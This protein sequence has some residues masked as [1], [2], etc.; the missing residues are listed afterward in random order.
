MSFRKALVLF[1][2][3]CAAL[4][5]ADARAENP[6]WPPPDTVTDL[7]DPKWWPSDSSYSGMWELFS[8]IPDS[9]KATVRQPELALG[10]GVHADRAWQK[11]IGD[12]R[13]LIAVLD[14]G[15]RWSE[16]DLVNKMYLNR[17]ELPEPDAA[18][19]TAAFDPLK[20]YDA[21]GDGVF[22]VQDYTSNS[23]IQEPTLPCDPRVLNYAG[24][25]DTNGNGVLDGQDLI[26]IFA[27][28]VDDD[29]NGYVDDIS[30]WD[31]FNNDNDPND[32]T[33]FGHG[34]G[35]ARDSSAEGN[36]NRGDIGVCPKCT[37]MAVRVGD[38]FVVDANNFALGVLFATDSGAAVVQE[39]TGAINNNQL[40]IGAIDYAY[41]NGVVIIGSAA[42]ENAFHANFPGAN[43]HT[44]Y[45]HAIV[46]DGTKVSTSTTF[47]N[48]NNCTNYGPRLELSTPGTGC[49]SEATGKTSGIAGLVYAAALKADIPFPTGQA[50][51]TDKFGAR[52]LTAEEVR[53]LLIN[54]VDDINVPESKT[55]PSKYPSRAGWE[56]RFGYGR[57]NARSAVDAVL[58]GKIPPEVDLASPGWFRVFYPERNSDQTI[59]LA[60]R[61]TFRKDR[62]QSMDVV[63]EW[64]PG[65]NP[66]ENQFQVLD[67]RKGLTD[68]IVGK[69]FD[70]DISKLTIDNPDMPAPDHSANK[71]LVTVRIRVTAHSS[72]LGDVSGQ[73]RK[74]FHISRDKDILPGFPVK[75]TASGESSPKT[76]DIDGDG[77]REIVVATA[78]GLL[79]VIGADGKEKPGFP[80]KLNVLPALDPQ[81]ANT[82]R[83]SIAFKAGISN[84]DPDS[85]SSVGPTSSPAIADIDGDGTVEIVVCSHDG[86]VYV[87]EPDGKTRSGFPVKVEQLDLGKVTDKDNVIDSGITGSP[88][89][90]DLD[91]DKKL[92][93]IVPAMDGKLYVWREDGSVQDGWPVQLQDPVGNSSGKPIVGR[94]VGSPAVGDIDG[95]GILDI[96]VGTNEK[97]DQFGPLYVVHGDGNKHAGGPFHK[98]WPKRILSLEVLPFVGEGLPNSPALADLN[99]DGLPEIAIG[100]VATAAFVVRNT[101]EEKIAF[102]FDQDNVDLTK[103]DWHTHIV[104]CTRKIT[105]SCAELEKDPRV[106][107]VNGAMENNTFGTQSKSKDNPSVVLITNA[108]FG[109]L[110]NDLQPD[111]VMPMGGFGAAKTFAAGGKRGDFEHHVGAWDTRTRAYMPGFPTRIDDWQFFATPAIA[112]IDGDNKPEVL[113]SSAGY[114]VHAWNANGESPAGWPKLTGQWNIGTPAVGDLTG[115]G[116]LEVVVNTRS[117]WLY[118]WKTSGK[119]KDGRIDWANFGHDN[120]NTRNFATKLSQ[121]ISAAELPGSDAGPSGDGGGGGDGGSGGD[122]GT[123]SGDGGCCDVGHGSPRD[124]VSGLLILV[125]LLIPVWRRRRRR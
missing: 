67:E 46:Y 6:N 64:A 83:E 76:A 86:W 42:D 98:G 24:G 47:L 54:T 3:V 89:L 78:D 93:I 11:T 122:G 96:V 111:L 112:D 104:K 19:R 25:W 27:D 65:A 80:A 68:H 90:A 113:A 121:G 79:H 5:V 66:D 4:L 10:S 97:L 85:R 26:R 73:T 21:N 1:V 15:I 95:D 13:V 62:F 103:P 70:W 39:A 92:E 56:Q 84:I 28:G 118:A 29:A 74:A 38:S 2:P 30:G 105:E 124:T 110:N 116:N 37:V 69:I 41:N 61:I 7:S 102:C 71:R 59:S 23:G 77:K 123:G 18:C 57:T 35:E 31:F 32:D 49:S 91:G 81:R 45:T 44:V 119:A 75:L 106:Q 50:Y 36:N 101:A 115:D 17:G 34:T 108:A 33:N 48:F 109:D 14:S 8:F 88:V 51:A 9:A 99:G 55:D 117:G 40:T 100:G 82:I 63:V 120:R 16:R 114:W 58:A 125:L 72:T 107:C 94:I 20:P 43:D 87:F 22:N 52:R 12:P 53:Q 60:G